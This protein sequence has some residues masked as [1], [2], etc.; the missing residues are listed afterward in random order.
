MSAI[1]MPFFSCDERRNSRKHATLFGGLHVLNQM[2][3]HRLAIFF[4]GIE[5]GI[6]VTKN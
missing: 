2:A 6:L 5:T 3:R 1:D 4:L